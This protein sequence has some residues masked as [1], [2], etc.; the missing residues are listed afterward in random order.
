MT[1][2]EK[3]LQILKNSGYNVSNILVSI[4]KN[5]AITHKISSDFNG[6]SVTAVVVD[7]ELYGNVTAT[8][9]DISNVDCGYIEDYNF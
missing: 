2:T 9:N 6:A 7:T 8:V 3:K 1:N 4:D 5:H